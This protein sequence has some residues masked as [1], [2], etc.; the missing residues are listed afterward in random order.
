MNSVILTKATF[1]RNVKDYKFSHKL[2]NDQKQEIINKV[3]SVLGEDYELLTIDKVSNSVLKY[4]TENNLINNNGNTF[5]INKKEAICVELFNGEHISITATG[6]NFFK[7]ANNVAKLIENK[8]SL[9]YSDDLG[10]YMSN[11]NNIGSGIKLECDICLDAICGINKLDQ[12]KQN[13]AMLGYSLTPTNIKSIYKI[14]TKCSLGF[15]ESEVY[16]NFINTITKL[17]ELEVESAKMLD[18][19][20]HD[21]IIDNV[22]RSYA[23]LNSAHIINIEELTKHLIILRTG[24]NLGIVDIS[25]FSINKLQKLV[26]NKTSLASKAEC[27]ELAKIVKDIIKGDKNV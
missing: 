5:I 3:L 4:L 10:Y 6:E 20:S 9:A 18:V 15:S 14:T 11:L 19:S 27:V 12:V 13:V 16:E 7:N 2:T 21:E 8:I 23:I 26:N 24:L 1:F 17:Q 22:S 25:L